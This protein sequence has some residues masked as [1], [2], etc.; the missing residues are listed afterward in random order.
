MR[1]SHS[2]NAVMSRACSAWTST[3]RVLLLARC[4]LFMTV[5]LQ[6]CLDQLQVS[7]STSDQLIV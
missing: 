2:D 1:S 3:E 5:K 4:A 6:L 7:A